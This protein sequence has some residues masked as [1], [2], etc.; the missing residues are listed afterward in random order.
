MIWLLPMAVASMQAEPEHAPEP[1][2]LGAPA[3]ADGAKLTVSH[4]L[5]AMMA[6]DDAAYDKI[7]RGMAIMVAPDMAWPVTRAK[8]EE[9]LAK[10]SIPQVVST[11]PFPKMPEVQAVRVAMRC[12]DKDHSKGVATVADIMAD[13][14]HAF[15]VLPGGVES[16]WPA[17]WKGK[18]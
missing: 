18:P 4:L 16:V 13:N 10:C 7:A 5:E 15:M 17:N 14:E 12:R 9:T 6:K 2:N 11:R 8:F 3:T 1:Y